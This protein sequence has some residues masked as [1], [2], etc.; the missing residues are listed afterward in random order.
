MQDQAP[1]SVSA[2]TQ[3]IKLSLERAFPSLAIVGELSNVK[4][5]TSGHLYFTL[6]DES[7][8]MSGV[9]WRSRVPSLKFRPADGMK[10]VVQGR[11]HRLRGAGDVSD[12]CDVHA[13]ARCG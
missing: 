7:A 4:L 2:L 12:R 8:Q 13:D 1:L 10:V 5:H 9:M 11:H 6:K 3:R